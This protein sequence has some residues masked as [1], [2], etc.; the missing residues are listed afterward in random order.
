M[1]KTLVKVAEVFAA[2]A[3]LAFVV[4]LFFNGD[5]TAEVQ[6]G[7]AAAFPEEAAAA[8][9][10]KNRDFPGDPTGGGG[11]T[12]TTEAEPEPEPEVDGAALFADNCASCHGNDGGGGVGPN[13]Q[14]LDDAG[15]VAD[16]VTDGRGGMPSFEGR[17]EPEE[18]EAVADYVTSEL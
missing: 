18:I 10:A 16:T 1:L 17:L 9:E 5:N 2:A 12:T 3:A 13:L 8:I 15:T 11:E 4:L 14:D 6:A 7:P